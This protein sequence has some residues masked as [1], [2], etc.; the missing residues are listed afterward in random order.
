MTSSKVLR[1][2]DN[3]RSLRGSPGILRSSAGTFREMLPLIPLLPQRRPPPRLAE[4]A[5]LS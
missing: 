4:A 3:S 2:G 5:L 1:H